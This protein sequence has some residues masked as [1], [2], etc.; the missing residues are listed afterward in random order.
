MKCPHCKSDLNPGATT[1]HSCG[2]TESME[3]G[4]LGRVL[5]VF[6]YLWACGLLFFGCGALA[7]PNGSLVEMILLW[8][9]GIGPAVFLNRFLRKPTWL[10]RVG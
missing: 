8:A 3:L 6:A 10:K 2:A 7:R 4:P 9:V 1:C 5:M